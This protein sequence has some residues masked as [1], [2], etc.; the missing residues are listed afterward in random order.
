MV[1]IVPKSLLLS[2]ADSDRKKPDARSA[3]FAVGKNLDLIRSFG[4]A[5]TREIGGR[6]FA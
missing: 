2:V 1:A 3:V 5:E 6:N 4:F